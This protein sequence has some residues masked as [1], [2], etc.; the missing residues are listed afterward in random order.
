MSL[1]M[2][3]LKKAEQAKREAE[4]P[5]PAP[6][7]T[8][9]VTPAIAEVR[10]APPAPALAPEPAHKPESSA[11][12][13]RAARK[14]ESSAPAPR[15][16]RKPE[17]SAPAPRAAHKPESSAPAPQA[18]HKPEPSAPASETEGDPAPPAGEL[19]LELEMREEQKGKIESP[20]HDE[21]DNETRAE[22]PPPVTRSPPVEPPPA[23]LAPA[24]PEPAGAPRAHEDD[25]AA[26]KRRAKT[27]AAAV[28]P[29]PVISPPPP[30][31]PRA[32]PHR[33]RPSASRR[34]Q[35]WLLAGLIAI[36]IAALG[37]YQLIAQLDQLD[38]GVAGGVLAMEQA[39]AQVQDETGMV[40]DVAV[41]EP[42]ALPAETPS[43]PSIAEKPAPIPAVTVKPAAPKQTP[44]PPA[45]KET[46]AL[47][48]P[49]ISRKPPAEPS[50]AQAAPAPLH[51][52]RE[53]LPDPI[54]TVL[55]RA[56]E[57]YQAGDLSEAE[58]QYRLVIQREANNRDALL[59]LA[60]VAQRGARLGEARVWYARVLELNPK[61]SAAIASLMAMDG[62]TA[63][64]QNE[65][66]VKLLI[67]QEPTAAH[68][69]FALGNLYAAQSR[70]AEAQQA[71]F[72][73]YHYDPINGDY[74]FNLAVSLDRMGQGSAALP[75]YRLA[76]AAAA[77]AAVQYDP[78]AVEQRIDR[79]SRVEN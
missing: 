41:T 17:S 73:A 79:L 23:A 55:L 46:V 39:Q 62:N 75:Y 74:A 37:F 36:A 60:A 54:Y 42:V 53:Q 58:R 24:K 44:P 22:T 4:Q 68:L 29:G 20:A 65:S 57:A 52:V 3:A 1:L 66:R 15:A 45:E 71:F 14:P 32:V 67:E 78:A 11:P 25:D 26:L 33:A 19:H 8:R 9:E 61:D 43:A 27:A 48:A 47:A 50:P 2:E 51:I 30:Q 64:V 28:P 63:P 12:A 7:A 69:H 70:W 49:V 35:V 34:R 56:Y 31:P 16:A 18:A 40:E 59:G 76:L 6:V 13:P 38:A 5:A 21:A 77:R 72:N 10:L